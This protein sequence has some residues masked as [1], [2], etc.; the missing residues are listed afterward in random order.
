MYLKNQAY[1][2]KY[3]W[4]AVKSYPICGYEFQNGFR[5]QFLRFVSRWRYCWTR[6]QPLLTYIDDSFANLFLYS[7][8]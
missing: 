4:N 8:L 5:C 7:K 6:D 1:M 3:L 2:T